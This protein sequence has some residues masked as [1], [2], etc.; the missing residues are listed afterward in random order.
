MQSDDNNVDGGDDFVSRTVTELIGRGNDCPDGGC[1]TPMSTLRWFDCFVEFFLRD[2]GGGHSCSR[3]QGGEREGAGGGEEEEDDDDDILYFVPT[4][5]TED[6]EP[7][8]PSAHRLLVKRRPMNGALPL[9]EAVI[10]WEETFAINLLARLHCHLRL[11]VLEAGGRIISEVIHRVYADPV[12]GQEQHYQSL[13]NPGRQESETVGMDEGVSTSNAVIFSSPSPSSSSSSFP[14]HPAYPM[15]YF[16]CHG[17]DETSGVLISPGQ[18][19]CVELQALFRWSSAEEQRI[20]GQARPAKVKEPQQQQQQQPSF[21]RTSSYV[22]WRTR[23]DRLPLFQGAVGHEALRRVH[24][25]K[26]G[27][28]LGAPSGI[29][30]RGPALGSEDGFGAG[31]EKSFAQI[32]VR[33][34]DAPSLP[35]HLWRKLLRRGSDTGGATGMATTNSSN[36][37]SD[38]KRQLQCQLRFIYMNWRPLVRAIFRHHHHY[39]HHNQHQLHQ[40]HHVNHDD[41][42]GK[43]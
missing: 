10:R 14:F 1:T 33:S 39:N 41:R 40:G 21:D 7:L 43:V 42:Q 13:L 11:T 24:R 18:T 20:M 12:R 30:M 6:P 35:V 15:I 27:L 31:G 4:N 5:Q 26:V 16:H 34:I 19:L 32:V 29:L 38:S 28:H 9:L 23:S 36:D 3:S 2:Q 22:A 8:P 17:I 25:R 37:A